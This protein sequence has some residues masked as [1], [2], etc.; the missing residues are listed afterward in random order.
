MSIVPNLV[1]REELQM[2]NSI[3]QGTSQLSV[4]IGP[5]LAGGVIAVFASQGA[6]S[7]MEGVGLAIAIDA[8]TLLVS[9]ISLLLMSVKGEPKGDKKDV[10]GSIKEGIIYVFR[11]PTLRAILLV[12]AALNFLFSGPFIVG[13]PVLASTRLPEGVA[14]FGLMLSAYGGGNLLGIILCGAL[15]KPKARSVGYIVAGVF[16]LFGLGEILF[17]FM[18][19]T[20]ADCAILAFLGIFNGYVGILFITMLQKMTPMSMM[21]RLMSLIMLCGVGLL[22]IS[23]ALTGFL[24][25]YSVEGLYA[26]VGLLFIV[27]ALISIAMPE[28]RNVG[29]KMP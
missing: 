6:S 21:G 10:L 7:T 17:G 9:V 15:P 13:I 28:I 1:K 24:I 22:P 2:A 14:A 8:F 5:A 12:M 3:M 20:L 16:A 29:Y 18:S 19:S 11:D 27:I 23:Q 26:A 25:K 4:F